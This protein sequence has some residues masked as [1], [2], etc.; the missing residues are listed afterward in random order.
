MRC[1]SPKEL[2]S[3]GLASI[4]RSLRTPVQVQ[5]LEPR[6]GFSDLE[7]RVSNPTPNNS[8][9]NLP[10]ISKTP[11]Y[12]LLRRAPMRRG[13]KVKSQ[14]FVGLLT[15]TSNHQPCFLSHLIIGRGSEL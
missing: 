3:Q 12:K 14:G 13:R 15:A 10:Q 2:S 8:P 5:N 1:S 4:P 11:N 6:S 9:S 7:N